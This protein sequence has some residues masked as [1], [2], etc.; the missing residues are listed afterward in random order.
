MVVRE[1]VMRSLQ[2][3]QTVVGLVDRENLQAVSAPSY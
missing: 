1:D 3:G 2:A